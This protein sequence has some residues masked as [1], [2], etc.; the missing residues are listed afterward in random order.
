MRHYRAESTPETRVKFSV[1]LAAL[2]TLSVSTAV[3]AEWKELA[4]GSVGR[5][6]YD[7]A[8]M[9]VKDGKTHL[10]YR[11]DYRN[12]IT[13]PATKKTSGSSTINVAVDCKAKTL[14]FLSSET[15]AAAEGKGALVDRNVAKD[16]T[17]EAVT[18]GSSNQLLWD[19][20]CKPPAAPAKSAAPAAP[21]APKK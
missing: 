4:T 10:K 2:L 20:A 11:I 12:L 5:L 15:H 18:E 3:H 9:R 19:L 1:C 14:S 16:P 17:S 7:P 13:D 8:S 6:S 21:A